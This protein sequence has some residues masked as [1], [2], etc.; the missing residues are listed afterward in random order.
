MN[1][2]PMQASDED[3]IDL[4]LLLKIV[5]KNKRILI[6]SV[7]ISALLGILI[8]IGSPKEFI[9]KTS[10]IPQSSNSNGKSTG[11][12][13]LAAIAGV[14]LDA[15]QSAESLSPMI[16]PYVM[17]SAPFQLDLMNHPFHIQEINQ[18]V[19]LLEFFTQYQKP[20]TLS[21]VKKY[22]IGLPGILMKQ[23][24]GEVKLFESQSSSIQF[25]EQEESISKLLKDQ[26]TLTINEKIG[27]LTIEAKF[28]DPYLAA[29]V[30][31]YTRILLQKY[32]TEFKIQKSKDQL[33]FIQTLYKEKEA[34]FLKAQRKLA[35]FRDQ[36]QFART[37]ISRTDEERLQAQYSIASSVYMELAKQL[38]QAKIKVKEDTPVFLVVEPTKVPLEKSSPKSIL[39]LLVFIIL[40]I[41]IGLGIVFV[42]YQLPQVRQHWEAV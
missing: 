5:W 20:S 41:I 26:V 37:A 42:K 27:Y 35:G 29:Q 3:E 36:N 33:E 23:F 16:F 19:S 40:G 31:D 18:K 9:S 22:T 24:S 34:D 28:N 17:E 7:A 11:L 13:G 2:K 12:S 32:L 6:F 25:T 10:M 30:A 15:Q 1:T 8:I 21:L 4:I 39:I 14:S 38:E